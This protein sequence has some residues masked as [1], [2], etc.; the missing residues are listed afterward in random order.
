[1]DESYEYDFQASRVERDTM[2]KTRKLFATLLVAGLAV[3]CGED[4][5]L[6]V[7][8]AELAGTWTSTTWTYSL[9][10]NADTKLQFAALLFEASLVVQE[11]GVY[12]GILQI[13][14]GVGGTVDVPINGTIEVRGDSLLLKF[15]TTFL[16]PPT[17][18]GA[19]PPTGN[20]ALVLDPADPTVFDS[21]LLSGNQLTLNGEVDTWPA[22]GVPTFDMHL[23]KAADLL[24]VLTRS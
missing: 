1:M 15:A 22:T 11:S 19:V 3:G 5:P 24:I 10:E 2:N 17:C 23:G 8:V 6:G 14:D 16:I 4:D 7:T 18:S 21:F 12:A 20:C 9:Q 13:P